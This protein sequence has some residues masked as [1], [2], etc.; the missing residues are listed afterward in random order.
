M[1]PGR[2]Y[3][4]RAAID[5]PTIEDF[6]AAAEASDLATAYEE[7]VRRADD[8]SDRLRRE[9]NRVANRATLQAHQLA[10]QQQTAELGRQLAAAGE[11]CERIEAQWRQTWQAAGIDPLPPREMQAWIQRQHALVQQSQIIRQRTA[12]LAQLEEQIAAHCQHVGQA[13]HG[14]VVPEPDTTSQPGK[15]DLRQADHAYKVPEPDLD[16]LLARGDAILEQIRDTADS[17]RQL[18]REKN[19]L[20]KAVAQAE[21]K[22]A[23]AETDLTQW[24]VQWSA[25][26][27]PLGLPAD[28]SPIAVNEV[29]AQ[30]AELLARLNDA[31]G[32]A[33]RIEGI[34]RDSLRFRQNVER[35]LQT[36]DPDRPSANDRFQEA[37][38][39]LLRRLRRAMSDQKNLDLLRSQRKE[40]DV[41][42]QQAH[43]AVETL[44]ARL[45]VPC[46][47]ARC[48]GPEGLPAAEAASA[49]VL[50]LRQEQEACHRTNCCNLPR[51]RRSMLSW[52]RRR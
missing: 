15:A 49:E 29:V 22:A 23:Q 16:A 48:Q 18:E 20:V 31:A 35:L 33:E 37:F 46:Q 28:A 45:A 38:E 44:R 12:S 9:A 3:D 30:T 41:K 19:R 39:D 17:R 8:L 11:H 47:E 36:I 52:P 2:D 6:L 5:G 32:F 13:D 25:A 51:G 42:R 43:T 40:Q 4:A 27:Q 10:L 26:I 7:T 21:A 14:Y 50:R 34:G 24:R 1:V